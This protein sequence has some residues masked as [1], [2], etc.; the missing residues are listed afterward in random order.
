MWGSVALGKLTNIRSQSP[1]VARED[2]TGLN[3]HL[4]TYT[5]A[6]GTTT[7]TG[8]VRSFISGD[9]TPAKIDISWIGANGLV[10]NHVGSAQQLVVT[11]SQGA[12]VYSFPA[13]LIQ[14]SVEGEVGSLIT[15]SAS[16]EVTS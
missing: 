3:A 16:F 15:G 13:C 9:I 7:H 2:V 8:A 10:W 6:D 12:I 11:H 14:F 1:V 4:V 5:A